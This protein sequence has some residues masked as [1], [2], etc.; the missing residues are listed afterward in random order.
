MLQP[1]PPAPD[2]SAPTIFDAGPQPAGRL[3][4]RRVAR[5]SGDAVRLIWSAARGPFLAG[6]ALSLLRGIG[7]GALLLV[8]QQGVQRLLAGGGE[9]ATTLGDVLPWVAAFAGVTAALSLA[10]AV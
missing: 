7:L 10:G 8:G 4:A 6:V 1:G 5:V 9:S 2:D 3:E